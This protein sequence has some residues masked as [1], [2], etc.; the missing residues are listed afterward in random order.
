M[1]NLNTPEIR[2]PEFNG[3]WKSTRFGE[4]G[5]FSKG[6]GIS[7]DDISADG[8]TECIRYG[9]LYTTYN[10]TIENVKSKTKVAKKDLVLSEANDIIIP[11]SG[12]TQIDI[13]TASCVLKSGIALGGDLNIIKTEN[14]GVFLSYY[15]NSEKKIDIAK[16]AQGISVVHLYSSQLSTLNLKLPTF[17]EQQKIAS[18][19]TAIDQKISQ[20]KQKKTLLEQYKKGV[21]QKIFSQEIRFKDENGQEFPKWEKKR[22][23]DCLD[24]LQPT[25]FIVKNT[26]YDDSYSIPVLTAGKSFILGY[27]DEEENIFSNPL[28]VI[29]FDDFTTSSQ[30]VDFSFKVKSSAM[31]ILVAKQSMDI[32]FMFEALKAIRYEVG[33]H[34]RHWISKFAP[35]EIEVPSIHEQVK[36]ADF[37]TAIDNKINHTQTQIE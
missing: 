1:G 14:N 21:M 9:E 19:F 27:T 8:V 35:L 15:L 4:I 34:E 37:F 2:F 23:G 30:F 13:A 36:I 26:D 10:E 22:L 7:K 3:D 5:K 28:P 31:K 33:G 6:K 29:I 18:F 11:A 25:K 20:L 24:Y 32:K 17:P 12:E 16:L